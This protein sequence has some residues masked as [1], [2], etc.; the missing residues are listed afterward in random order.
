MLAVAV[1]NSTS[2]LVQQTFFAV[3]RHVNPI[4]MPLSS[5]YAVQ[6][7]QPVERLR[8]LKPLA[9]VTTEKYLNL[10]LNAME[11]LAPL[12]N[13]A[14]YHHAESISTTE[15]RAEPPPPQSLLALTEKHL[16]MMH[17]ALLELHQDILL[18]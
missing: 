17:L 8:S 18:I 15:W 4:S 2:K 9:L 12:P 13:V 1:V 11:Q 7:T 16:P 14:W 6:P 3:P 5:P 10:M